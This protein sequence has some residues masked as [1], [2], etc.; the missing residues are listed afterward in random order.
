MLISILETER[1]YAGVD[2][3]YSYTPVPVAKGAL[4][5]YQSKNGQDKWREAATFM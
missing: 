2:D 3:P 4:C 5:Y 1:I